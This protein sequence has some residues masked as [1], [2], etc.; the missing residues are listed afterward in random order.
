MDEQ[1]FLCRFDAGEKFNERELRYLTDEDEMDVIEEIEGE[2]HRW[3]RE[4]QTIFQAGGRY[5]SLCW[6][7]G[8]TECQENE[9]WE[10]PIEV[11]KHTYQK[12]ITVTEWKP[13]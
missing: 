7:R 5:F 12:T 11:R 6:R 2:D 8:L 10:Q 3:D 9:F 4:I 1:E 13:I